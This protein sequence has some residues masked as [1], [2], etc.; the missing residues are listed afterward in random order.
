MLDGVVATNV[1]AA[2][3][4]ANSYLT[5]GNVAS[6]WR[7]SAAGSSYEFKFDL[8]TA[9]APDF[10]AGFDMIGVTKSVTDVMVYHS[11]D[12]VTYTAVET[13]AWSWAS[14]ANARGDFSRRFA[15]VSKR[16]WKII[17]WL[18]GASVLDVGEFWLGRVYV[19]EKTFSRKTVDKARGNV[20]NTTDGGA[21]FVGSLAAHRTQMQLSFSMLKQAQHES[22]I[23]IVDTVNG[24]ASP[25]VLVPDAKNQKDCYHGRIGDSAPWEEGGNNRYEGLTISFSEDG[26]AL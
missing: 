20:L 16:Y 11:P 8:G 24:A 3:G 4:Y 25:V 1:T 10:V 7:S 14:V 17:V 12:A 22:I 6:A 5:D 2:T 26:R 9:Q 19:P 23:E 21:T 15:E 13:A 18:A